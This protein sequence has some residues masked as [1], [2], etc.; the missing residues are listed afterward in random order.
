MIDPFVPRPPWI[1]GDLQTIR[2]TLRGAAGAMPMARA[3][4]LVFEAANGKDRLAGLLDG[5][6][7]IP[8]KP[9][10]IIVHGLNGDGDGALTNTTAS[11][12]RAAGWPTLRL[13]LRGA[14]ANAPFCATTYHSGLSADLAAMLV[15]LPTSLTPAGIVLIGFSAGGNQVLKL[16]GEGGV[17]RRVRA[18][19]SVCA[20]ISLIDA[21]HR[22]MAA[23]NFF[24][25]RYLLRGLKESIQHCQ[26]SE[27]LLTGARKARSI[28]DFDDRVTAPMHGFKDALDFYVQGASRPYLN[29]ISVPTLVLA[30]EDDPWIP[31]T[32]Y[33]DVDWAACPAITPIIAASGGHCGFHD[34]ASRIPWHD[35]QALNFLTQATSS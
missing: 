22:L 20:P 21:V 8:S 10:A 31:V 26:V 14:G 24:Y 18:A 2:N 30:A 29:R 9:L 34:K 15:Q 16:L 32:S 35:R 3:K 33:T 11:H 12:F 13:T 17:D 1:G 28:Y 6:N 23:R 19:V 7:E 4:V 5:A 27:A 25:H